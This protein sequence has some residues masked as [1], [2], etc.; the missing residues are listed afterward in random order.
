MQYLTAKK[1]TYFLFSIFDPIFSKD[2]KD[3]LRRKLFVNFLNKFL[4]LQTL[5]LLTEASEIPSP[6]PPRGWGG[7]G[8]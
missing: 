8:E 1:I 6:F 3:T 4:S 2:F 5:K 7:G